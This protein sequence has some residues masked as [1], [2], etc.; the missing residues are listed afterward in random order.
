L[1][2]DETKPDDSVLIVGDLDGTLKKWFDARPESV[3]LVRPD[4]I[5]GGVSAAQAASDMVRGYDLAIGALNPVSG[6]AKAGMDMAERIAAGQFQL[7]EH[8]GHWPQGEQQA[9]FD[10]IVLDFLGRKL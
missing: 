9:I 5:V 1:P 3:V 10:Q 7:I 4:R 6:P 8:A 2:W